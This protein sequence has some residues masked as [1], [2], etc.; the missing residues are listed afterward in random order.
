MGLTGEGGLNGHVPIR[1]RTRF[2]VR[3]VAA[4]YSITRLAI[5]QLHAGQE[6]RSLARR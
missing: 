2:N 3:I 6:I 5:L 1:L 4:D